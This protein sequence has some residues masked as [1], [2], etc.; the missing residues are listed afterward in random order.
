MSAAEEVTA[1][2]NGA[3][4]TGLPIV[5]TLSFDTG[6][7]TMMGL[8]PQGAV[9][10]A[11]SLPNA[12]WRWV[13]IAASAPTS[14]WRPSSAMRAVADGD[15]ILVAKGN[16]GIPE[17]RDGQIHYTGTPEIMATYARLAR[18][19]GAGIIGG[20]CGTTS[21]HLARDARRRST[22]PSAARSPTSPPSSWRSA[23]WALRRPASRTA[24][25]LDGG[26]DSR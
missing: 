24:A 6:G 16:C 8:T 17:F 1:A 4:V 7:R 13:R 5:T 12:P 14:W 11:G 20:C 18:D 15:T 10:M 9:E 22:P 2:V 3:A 23:R 25:A 19:A 21:E 26:G